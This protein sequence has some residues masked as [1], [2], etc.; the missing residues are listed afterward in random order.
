MR[1][2]ALLF[3]AVTAAIPLANENAACVPSRSAITVSNASSVGLP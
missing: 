1:L 3:G 2:S